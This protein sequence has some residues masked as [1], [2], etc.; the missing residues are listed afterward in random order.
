MGLRY[1]TIDQLL[2]PDARQQL[3][4]FSPKHQK[5]FL[6]SQISDGIGQGVDQNERVSSVLK[7]ISAGSA[8]FET[9][10]LARLPQLIH[11]LGLSPIESSELGLELELVAHEDGAFIKEHIDTA[12]GVGRTLQG[13]DRVVT[14]V[15]YFFREPRA[16]TGGVLRLLPFPFVAGG[17][18]SIDIPVAQDMA[19]A[20]PSWFPHEVL[21][22]AC[23]SGDFSD[24]RFAI[25]CW[26]RKKRQVT[27]QLTLS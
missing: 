14:I 1:I 6:P 5:E 11:S 13:T 4:D 23:P 22:V 24:A 3:L 25:N 21:P 8:T 18:S 7:D 26:V 27:A 12:T 2:G 17:Q 10:I 20:F 15:Y 16:F 9:K 19:V